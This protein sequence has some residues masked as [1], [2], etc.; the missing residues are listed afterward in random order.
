[1][2][3]LGLLRVLGTAIL[4]FV[5]SAA[6]AETAA[7]GKPAT[8]GNSSELPANEFIANTPYAIGARR[9]GV[10]RCIPR[11]NQVTEFLTGTFPNSGQV[12]N[13]VTG[14]VNQRLIST[15]I[16]V[17]GA[18]SLS[19]ASASFAPAANSGLCSATYDL[20][21]YWPQECNRVAESSFKTFKI[22]KPLYRNIQALESGP[23]GRV[24]LMPAGPKGCVSIKKEW[25][26]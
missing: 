25:L 19:F 22:G 18:D 3:G 9:N 26:F 16:E 15:V 21:T 14:D 12:F 1:M 5:A 17:A 10:I 24:Y 6:S 23:Y 11:I 7:I 8:T 2:A 20:V 4:L 13:D